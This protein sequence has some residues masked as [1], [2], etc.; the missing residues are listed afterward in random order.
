[1]LMDCIN[2]I[3]AVFQMLYLHISP[4][5]SIVLDF[6][7]KYYR[8]CILGVIVT[9]IGALI[10]EKV[11]K[12]KVGIRIWIRLLVAILPMVLLAL[13]LNPETGSYQNLQAACSEYRDDLLYILDEIENTNKQIEITDR[14][15]DSSQK[16]AD[17]A[18]VDHDKTHYNVYWI[19]YQ[20]EASFHNY[21]LGE[22]ERLDTIL[23]DQKER[24]NELY[25]QLGM[26]CLAD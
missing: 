23:K 2:Y 24:R 7:V 15:L 16:R 21:L 1:M 3:R 10:W 4:W 22:K 11:Q 5:V 18:K 13:W 12:G 25:E 17:K 20:Y 6:I 19:E 9:Q 26:A 8:E 14:I